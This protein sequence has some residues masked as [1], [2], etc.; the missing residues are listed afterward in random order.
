MDIEVD[1]G[2]DA[3]PVLRDPDDFKG[4]KVVV[5]GGRDRDAVAA[6]LAGI[7]TWADDDHVAVERDAVR[8]LAGERADDPEWRQGF[9]TM[10]AY[11]ESKGWTVGEAIRAHVEWRA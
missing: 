2:S 4:F 10:V 3:G 6:A 9:E 5:A 8:A 11:A 1:L 7:A